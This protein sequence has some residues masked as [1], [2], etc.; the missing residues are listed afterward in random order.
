MTANIEVPKKE[1][2]PGG[3]NPAH[4]KSSYNP[5]LIT[6]SGMV[7]VGNSPI[8]S[9]TFSY[10][11]IKSFSKIGKRIE[12]NADGTLEKIPLGDMFDGV[13]SRRTITKIDDFIAGLAECSHHHALCYGVF[14][15]E[16][17][18]IVTKKN[19]ATNPGAVARSKEDMGWQ[20][21]GGILFLDYDPG[22][23]VLSRDELVAA[24]RAA[25]PFLAGVKMLW[26]PSASSMIRN[27]ETGEML[28][29]VAGQRLYI[30][31]D[32]AGDIPRIGKN[33]SDRLWLA[34]HGRY[35]VSCAGVALLR[36]LVDTSVW[37][38]NKL[39]FTG[40]AVC[41]TPL[42]QAPLEPVLIEGSKEYLST[43]AVLSLTADEKMVFDSNRATAHRLIEPQLKQAREAYIERRVK[44]TVP[45]DADSETIEKT[46]A[47][48]TEAVNKN[49][50]FGDFPLTHSSKKIV[51]VGEILDNPKKWHGEHFADPLEPEYDGCDLRI[52]R[53][54]LHSGG[55]PVIMS[56]AHGSRRFFLVRSTK[57]IMMEAGES[58]NIADRVLEILR[59]EGDLYEAGDAILYLAKGVM[60]PVSVDWLVDRLAR[61]IKF[62][63]FDKRSEKETPCDPPFK[64]AKTIIAK[65]G[66]R[67]FKQFKALATAPTI[68]PDGRV[69]QTTGYDAETGLLLLSDVDWPEI[70]MNPTI[71]E[72]KAAF[73][74]LWKPFEKFPFGD[75]VDRGVHL[76]SLLTAI[77]RPTLTTAPAH[78]YDAP[79]AGSGKT[80]LA[81]AVGIVA[82][83]RE[84]SLCPPFEDDDEARKTV[85]SFLLKGASTIV[86]D[87][88]NGTLESSFFSMALTT[89][90]LECRILGVSQTATVANRAAWILTGNNFRPVG[91][92]VRRVLTCRIDPQ[93]EATQVY[94]REFALDPVDYCKRHRLSMVADGLLLLRAYITAGRPKMFQGR[95]ASFEEWS[96]LIQQAVAWCGAVGIG[97]VKD[98][99]KA[100]DRQVEIDP[101]QKKLSALFSAWYE[102]FGSVPQSI[103]CL[104]K[105]A[106]QADEAG[107][108]LK[109]A[110]VEITGDKGDRINSRQLG[111]WIEARRGKIIDGL[112]LALDEKNMNKVLW[113]KISKIV[114]G[115]SGVSGVSKPPTKKVSNDI[116]GDTFSY[117]GKIT[118]ITPET[119]VKS[120]FEENPVSEATYED[121]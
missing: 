28:K 110:L 116:L 26:R 77:A 115:V 74:R 37:Q 10:T 5:D 7:Q 57:K 80:L 12:L 40:G 60:W 39:D 11:L 90:D 112:L 109:N 72:A 34:G 118:P 108:I 119:P 30:A 20:S 106:T 75:S 93:M 49:T 78:A 25:C 47:T 35:D 113:W 48:F 29:E 120:L 71:D 2:E 103:N 63:R 18:K 61:S 8:E 83:G 97:D 98:P 16:S 22:E 85:F 55:R 59:E 62:E 19:K 69:I 23:T 36:T 31:V 66:E 67:G 3:D 43:A 38:A 56:F 99:G 91:E 65:R 114:T 82:L 64:I 24:I 42:V 13:F 4:E 76:S 52:A 107:V 1:K 94:R 73:M 50:L 79:T 121:F 96:D 86:I 104:I 21:S 68:T 95:M 81:R 32:R 84:P 102:T 111:R 70:K 58:H 46:R 17:G 27:S 14:E 15:A 117:S 89:P 100:L 9:P 88:V 6:T 101:E 87:N 105:K 44:E 54:N 33:I 92:L 41:I 51:T 53:V 45:A